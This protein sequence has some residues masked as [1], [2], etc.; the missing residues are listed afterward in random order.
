MAVTGCGKSSL[1]V[2]FSEPLNI[3]L[4]DANDFHPAGNILKISRRAPLEDED[5]WPWL[6]I[7]G[8][9]LKA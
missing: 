4:P 7:L 2:A 6:E 5:L 3:P 1:D 9:A 8:K